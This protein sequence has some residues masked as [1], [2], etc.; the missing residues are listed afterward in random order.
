MGGTG[1]SVRS[2]FLSFSPPF[3]TE[4]DLDSVI[5]ALRSG[6][7]T[8]GPQVGAFE[9]AFLEAVD[10]SP[11][12]L[13]LSSCTAA[14]HLALCA[15]DVKPGDAVISTTMTFCSTIHAIEHMQAVP[16]LADVE[17]DTLNLSPE[18]VERILEKH[19]RARVTLP[20]PVAILPVHYGGHAADMDALYELASCYDL[21]V[22]DDA[23][24]ALPASVGE[25][26]IGS[27][28]RDPDIAWMTA[29]SF[30]ATKN[31][32][33]GEGGMLTG[34]AELVDA[35]RPWSLHGM[36]RDAW[37]RYG[38]VGKWAYDVESPGFKYNMTDLQAALGLSQLQRID[39]IAV[40]RREIAHRY[41]EGLGDVASVQLPVERPGYRHAW[42]LY[43][44][45]LRLDRLDIDR[46][47]FIGAMGA[48]NIG[49]SVH[50]IPV[51][52]LTY[53]REKY[54][55]K[56]DQFPVALEAFEGLVSLP[57]Y[58]AMT[59]SDVDDVMEAVS[60]IVAT[61]SR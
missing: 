49:T 37:N 9:Q 58:P 34:P 43:P 42:H 26:Q 31:I 45:R 36:S 7:I 28:P 12:A 57:I 55:F 22:I 3:I 11:A 51:H 53:Y 61:N 16:I 30:Y 1:R 10:A 25:Q 54:D 19:R 33:T 27:G 38:E 44:I 40:R 13:A 14:L 29:F 8:T 35:A 48:R 5:G 4:G 2:A 23:A 52:L 47:Q 32:T 56:P 39:E 15:M 41:A 46:S 50:F 59:D 18:A 6:W 60:D 20:Q 24:H 21:P 17:A